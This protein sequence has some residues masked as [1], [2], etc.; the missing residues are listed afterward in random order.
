[1]GAW[2]SG[3]AWRRRPTGRAAA[4]AGSPRRGHSAGGA[5]RPRPRDL[6]GRPDQ[7]GQVEGLQLVEQAIS[8]GGLAPTIRPA[9]GSG[10]APLAG[11]AGSAEVAN[12]SLQGGAASH[13]GRGA[14]ARGVLHGAPT[15]PLNQMAPTD[16]TCS[17]A[18]CPYQ[19]DRAASALSP[20]SATS[21]ATSISRTTPRPPST[22]LCWSAA[23]VTS[24]RRPSPPGRGAPPGRSTTW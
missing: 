14:P 24:T 7:L 2:A 3:P 8:C 21:W 5:R 6:P 9:S 13:V 17:T 18:P 22:S 19:A 10:A 16:L 11:H 1:M 23:P 20:H 4:D 12:G 15:V